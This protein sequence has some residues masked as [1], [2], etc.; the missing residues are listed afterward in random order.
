VYILGRAVKAVERDNSGDFVNVRISNDEELDKELDNDSNDRKGE[1]IKASHVVLSS[2]YAERF[3][4][5][6]RSGYSFFNL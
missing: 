3:L 5:I 6:T 1:C 2:S 4:G